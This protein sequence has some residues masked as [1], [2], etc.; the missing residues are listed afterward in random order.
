M[1]IVFT[2]PM[3]VFKVPISLKV[4]YDTD[5]KFAIRTVVPLVYLHLEKGV[6]IYCR[7]AVTVFLKFVCVLFFLL[8]NSSALKSTEFNTSVQG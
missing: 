1:Q 5:G 8:H 3:L 6:L 4:D 7:R 2:L